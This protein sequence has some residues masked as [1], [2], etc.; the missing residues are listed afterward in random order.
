VNEDRSRLA[1]QMIWEAWIGG[2]TIGTLPTDARPRDLAE[3]HAAQAELQLLA[4][5]RLGWKIAATSTAGQHHIGVDGPIAGRLFERFLYEDGATLPAE[6]LHMAVIEAEL[7]FRMAETLDAPDEMSRNDVEAA[8]ATMHLAIEVPD[9]RFDRYELAGAPQLVADN[10]CSG[11]FVLGREIPQ[12]TTLDLASQAVSLVV[13]G[14]TVA[15]GK[16]SNVLRHPLDA[17]TWLANER[18]QHSTPLQAG[19]IVTTG[20]MSVPPSIERGNRVIAVFDGLG[21][22][23]VRFAS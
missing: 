15:R 4:G 3:G 19:E 11:F 20:T 17:L 12:W 8:I 14:E 5:P 18:A 2:T 13:D 9:S 16:G 1:A 22:V 21:D 23:S 10:A 6:R 7:A